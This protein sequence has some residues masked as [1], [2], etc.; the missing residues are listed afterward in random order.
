MSHSQSVT[1]LSE[2]L[3][4]IRRRKKVNA[5][6]FRSREMNKQ[7]GAK[8]NEYD[9]RNEKNPSLQKRRE[10]KFWEKQKKKRIEERNCSSNYLLIPASLEKHDRANP[11]FSSPL[12]YTLLQSRLQFFGGGGRQQR[13]FNSSR[14]R[15][16]FNSSLAWSATIASPSSSFFFSFIHSSTVG[17][18]AASCNFCIC[19][20]IYSRSEKVVCKSC[21]SKNFD[22]RLRVDFSLC[23]WVSSKTF[24]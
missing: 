17:A 20:S 19:K 14:Y 22:W 5:N 6:W 21:T 13:N 9:N 24:I 4:G 18:C 7:V 12:Y 2:L 1:N 15:V 3:R 11:N 16:E 23:A 10:S 8:I